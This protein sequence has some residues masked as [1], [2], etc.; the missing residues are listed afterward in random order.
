[1]RFVSFVQFYIKL[2]EG[3]K[4][5]T[6]EIYGTADLYHGNAIID[7]NDVIA[8]IS[9]LFILLP[10]SFV[11]SCGHLLAVE[12]SDWNSDDSDLQPLTRCCQGCL[13]RGSV[14]AGVGWKALA[15]VVGRVAE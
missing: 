15:M 1:M 2:H 10:L 5:Y 8:P 6:T 9:L 13:K 12:R 11:R 7:H 3:Y 4:L 14:V